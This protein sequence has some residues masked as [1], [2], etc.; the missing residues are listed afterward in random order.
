MIQTLT[1]INLLMEMSQS[2]GDEKDDMEVFLIIE[3]AVHGWINIVFARIHMK[4]IASNVNCAIDDWSSSL[5]EKRSYTLM[6]GYARI[7]RLVAA[8]QITVGVLGII[9][10]FGTIIIV[11]NHQVV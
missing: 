8:F 11:N 10:Y 5:K 7:G 6:I 9:I 2:C 1:T 4:T 3:T